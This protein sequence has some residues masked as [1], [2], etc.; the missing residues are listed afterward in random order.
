MPLLKIYDNWSIKVRLCFF[1]IVVSTAS[2]LAMSEVI[3]STLRA[4]MFRQNKK[5]I[6]TRLH[7]LREIIGENSDYLVAV[8]KDIDRESK[9]VPEPLWYLRFI[10]QSGRVVLETPGMGRLI[11]VAAVPPPPPDKVFDE[12]D[13][14]SAGFGNRFFMLASDAVT[15]PSGAAKRLTIQVALDTTAGMVKRKELHEKYLVLAIVRP[16]SIRQ[17]CEQKDTA[18]R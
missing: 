2:S 3:Q 12:D 9:D 5:A 8:K 4:S 1:V 17:T 11:P 6:T 18:E 13:I 10:D 15:P 16:L 7:S 14:G